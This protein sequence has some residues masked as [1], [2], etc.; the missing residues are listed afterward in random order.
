MFPVTG[1]LPVVRKLEINQQAIGV[2]VNTKLF[3][4]RT[5]RP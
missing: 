1:V 5:K 2:W 4:N 3:D